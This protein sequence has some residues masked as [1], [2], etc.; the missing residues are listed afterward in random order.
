MPAVQLSTHAQGDY[1]I[2]IVYDR[3]EA[4]E[5]TSV[6]FILSVSHL[7]MSFHALYSL[8]VVCNI[9]K[10]GGGYISPHN[11]YPGKGQPAKSSAAPQ[12]LARNLIPWTSLKR[13]LK[14]WLSNMA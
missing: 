2:K 6:L 12:I 5:G 9:T 14:H 8:N 1:P 13:S 11:Y 10:S 7:K 4:R 3:S